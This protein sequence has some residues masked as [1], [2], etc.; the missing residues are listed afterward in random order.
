MIAL[1]DTGLILATLSV[2]ILLFASALISGSEIAF[3]SLTHNDF[4]RLKEDKSASAQ[5]I[6]KLKEKP[7]TLLAT[8]LISNN[9]INVAIAVI[10][11][12]IVQKSFPD[13]RLRS[14]AES[15]VNLLHGDPANVTGWMNNIRFLIVVVG[16]TFLLVLFGEV[17]PKIYAKF[18]NIKLARMM[19]S[20]LLILMNI[21]TP[22]SRLLVKGTGIIE[23][24]LEKRGQGMNMTNKEE[25]SEA[26]ELTVRNEV[27]AHREIDLLK[28]IVNFGD[29][30]VKQIM[31]S[32]VDVVAVEFKSTFR[33]LLE[34]VRE[35]GYSRIP[36][37]EED[38]DHITGILYVKD[39]LGH[40]K[41]P[42]DY[43]WQ[44]LIRTN[45]LFVPESKKIGELLRVFQ[46]QKL[47]MAIVVDEYG[48]TSGIVTL[49]D[50]LEEIIGDIRDE[51]DDDDEVKYGKIDDSNY[52]FDG[53]T[54][55]NDVC[56]ILGIE[57]N[58]FDDVRGDADS[59]AGL[60]LE[61]LGYMPKPDE[62][63]IYKHF[64]FK[65]KAVS[66]RRIE[67]IQI[68]ILDHK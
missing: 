27:D 32:R 56:R 11:D 18:N 34:I 47:H 31:R 2:I 26:I 4:A 57:T 48:G 5:N 50:I 65:V 61:I 39:L 36:V 41:E 58:T 13:E 42:D 53:K 51:F 29:V 14:W 12:F 35:S 19:A 43:E 22:L 16:V 23:A 64:K 15:L 9:F 67:R 40:L 45:V 20:P 3:F 7:R 37:Y 54:M 59:V 33:E 8:I 60:I 62:E 66:K 28:S 55:L 38:F 1:P 24:R 6:L 10:S 63:I 17:A 21:F 30:A 46:T 44:A 49:E 25:I 68:T 52:W